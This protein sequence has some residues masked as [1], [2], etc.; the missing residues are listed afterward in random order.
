MIRDDL[1]VLADALQNSRHDNGAEQRAELIADAG[2]CILLR[3]KA[4]QLFGMAGGKRLYALVLRTGG[5]LGQQQRGA[6][7]VLQQLQRAV[8][9]LRELIAKGQVII[10]CNKNHKS[11]SP[12]GVGA[13]LTTKINVKAHM[14]KGEVG[15]N[16][17]I[18]R[19]LFY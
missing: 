6:D 12:S 15:L 11:I 19:A 9:E 7:I 3:V 18:R 16:A 2:Q 1:N 14:I 13:K 4:G 10:P 5:A 17:H 8:E